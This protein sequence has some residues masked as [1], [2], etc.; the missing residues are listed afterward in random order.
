MVSGFLVK[1]LNFIIQYCWKGFWKELAVKLVFREARNHA[2]AWNHI[3]GKESVAYV[4]PSPKISCWSISS[5]EYYREQFDRMFL[6]FS[7]FIEFDSHKNYDYFWQAKILLKIVSPTWHCSL[8][9]FWLI[10]IWQMHNSTSLIFINLWWLITIFL[11][12]MI[13]SS[14]HH[15]IKA[16]I[17]AMDR[18]SYLTLK[19]SL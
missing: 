11:C 13:L 19:N 15:L 5:L 17:P 18:G 3:M 8:F 14:I 6:P 10:F 9:I 7:F 1:F 4:R 12:A 2:L 16:M